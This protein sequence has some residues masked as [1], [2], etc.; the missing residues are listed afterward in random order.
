MIKCPR[1]NL[2]QEESP[3]CEY[4]G[5]DFTVHAGPGPTAGISVAKWVARLIL[6]LAVCGAVIAAYRVYSVGTAPEA[7]PTV[8]N[9]SDSTVPSSSDKDLHKALKGLS[10][11]MGIVSEITGG[12]SKGSVIAMVV[13]SIVGFGYLTYGK[14]SQQILMIICGIGLMGYSYFITGTIYIILSGLVLSALPFVFASK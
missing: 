8:V 10:G 7:K 13:F 11:D 6:I 3:V 12:S 1:C 9:N 2:E 5:L 4:C 14:K